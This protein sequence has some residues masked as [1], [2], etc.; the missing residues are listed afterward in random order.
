MAIDDF[1]KDLTMIEGLVRAAKSGKRSG[2]LEGTDKRAKPLLSDDKSKLT[3]EGKTAAKEEYRKEFLSDVASRIQSVRKNVAE[4]PRYFKPAFLL[5]NPTP[6]LKV[7]ILTYDNAGRPQEIDLFNDVDVPTHNLI[8]SFVHEISKKVTIN[9]VDV[10]QDVIELIALRFSLLQ[11]TFSG[12]GGQI[13][14]LIEYGWQID[15][16]LKS[17]YGDKVKFTKKIRATFQGLELKYTPDGIAE[18]TMTAIVDESLPP[19]YHNFL[20]YMTLGTSPATTI[21]LFSLLTF[22]HLLFDT[23]TSKNQTFTGNNTEYGKLLEIARYLYFELDVRD[24]NTIRDILKA[25]VKYYYRGTSVDEKFDTKIT[26][27]AIVSIRGLWLKK[28]TKT[29]YKG[30]QS[31][32]KLSLADRASIYKVQTTQEDF[33]NILE[34]IDY[35]NI[36]ETLQTGNQSYKNDDTLSSGDLTGIL[37]DKNPNTKLKKVLKDSQSASK[38]KNRSAFFLQE[39]TDLLVP[40]A[41]DMWIHPWLVYNYLRE[42]FDT[43][44]ELFNITLAGEDAQKQLLPAII[45]MAPENPLEL[46][47]EGCLEL[48]NDELVFNSKVIKNKLDREKWCRKAREY[49]CG[50]TTTWNEYLK[51]ILDYMFVV[52]TGG[53]EKATKLAKQNKEKTEKEKGIPKKLDDDLY[54][55]PVK[56]SVNTFIAGPDEALQIVQTLSDLF[57]I[58]KT[59]RKDNQKN[60]KDIERALASLKTTLSSNAH[61]SRKQ[62][63]IVIKDYFPSDSMFDPQ[64][65]AQHILQAYSYRASKMQYDVHEYNPGWPTVWD[66]NFPD[67]MEFSPEFDYYAALRMVANNAD[68]QLKR[69]EAEEHEVKNKAIETRK[70]L[71]NVVADLHRTTTKSRN[72]KARNKKIQEVDKLLSEYRKLVHDIEGINLTPYPQDNTVTY[73]LDFE[74]KHVYSGTTGEALANKRKMQEFRKKM[75]MTALSTKNCS[76]KV[77]GDASFMLHDLGKYIFLKFIRPDGSLGMFTG[78][79]NILT[80]TDEISGGVFTTTFSLSFSPQD[81]QLKGQDKREFERL[82]TGYDKISITPG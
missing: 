67:V 11:K 41:Q 53:K 27:K 46:R 18:A 28:S 63:M 55:A 43:A 37:S 50:V 29:Y 15:K 4:P 1:K 32:D 70:E 20:P 14:L 3:N 25:I 30:R 45:E 31:F 7:N 22:V 60:S 71:L 82:W 10:N 61:G 42:R 73:N 56:M 57:Q 21:T 68:T 34:Q 35:A 5:D 2:D 74:K 33:V 16:E 65:G 52:Y 48:K 38:Y 8:R 54:Q 40:I 79:Y 24:I 69:Q 19:P 78:I 51:Q 12:A 80:I 59:S 13:I 44:V 23:L 66:I 9:L 17:G 62:V 58:K 49:R 75:M 76:L 77:L 64:F 6:F 72:Q 26:E 81:G 36:I 47:P 39:L